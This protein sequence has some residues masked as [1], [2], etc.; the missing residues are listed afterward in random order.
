MKLFLIKLLILTSI[1]ASII[2]GSSYGYEYIRYRD[3]IAYSED[4]F[5]DVPYNIQISNFGSSHGVYGFDYKNFSNKYTTFNF[6]LTSQTLSYDYLILKQYE[7]HLADGGTMFIVISNFSFGT[8][9]EAQDDFKSKNKRYYS[10]LMPKYIKQ[11]DWKENLKVKYLSMYFTEPLTVLSNIKKYRQKGKDT[12]QLGGKDFDYKKDADEAYK[13][14]IHINDSGDMIILQ[15]EIDAL[16]GM[17]DVCKSHDITPILITTP[18]RGEYNDKF[19]Q[20]FYTQFHD[21]IKDVCEKKGVSYYDYSHD[22]RF[23][24]SDEY[25]RNADHLTPLGAITF[26]D[27]VV[28]EL[29]INR[30]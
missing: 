8:D 14:H 12:Y 4:K 7:S 30:Q 22:Y 6:A 26:T 17:I 10:F 16:Y 15:K 21:L 28:K 27:I 24:E 1:V 2:L 25:E 9:E 20:K 5:K 18:Y 29:I 3:N 19:S 23:I 13:R 11:Y